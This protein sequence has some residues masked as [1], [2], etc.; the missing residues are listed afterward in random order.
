MHH[1]ARFGDPGQKGRQGIIMGSQRWLLA[2]QGGICTREKRGFG[3]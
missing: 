1:L 2:R 3:G